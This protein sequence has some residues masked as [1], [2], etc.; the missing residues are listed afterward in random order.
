M[1][2]PTSLIRQRLEDELHLRHLAVDVLAELLDVRDL[3]LAARSGVAAV[4]LPALERQRL[5]D[6]PVGSTEPGQRDV[7]R[8]LVLREQRRLEERVLERRRLRGV[9]L[10]E[11]LPGRD[12]RRGF[13]AAC[14]CRC[15]RYSPRRARARARPR[16]REVPRAPTLRRR[17]RDTSDSFLTLHRASFHQPASAGDLVDCTLC[18]RP[19]RLRSSAGRGPGA[20]PPGRPTPAS[21]R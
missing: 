14:C 21:R 17:F 19:A 5:V 9:H 2:L 20:T 6:L 18:R 16:A 1:I 10:A 7:A 12:D 15:S 8:H 3:E 13:A 4:V 11:P